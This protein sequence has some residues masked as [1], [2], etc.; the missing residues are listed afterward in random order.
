MKNGEPVG[1]TWSFPTIKL[2]GT[3]SNDLRVFPS[4][5]KP[6]HQEIW[7]FSELQ[8]MV[9]IGGTDILI[10][11]YG[12]RHSDEFSLYPRVRTVEHADLKPSIPPFS[13]VNLQDSHGGFPKSWGY[14]IN[15]HLYPLVMTNIAMEVMA[16]RNRWF[17]Q[18]EASIYFW[19]SPWL[20]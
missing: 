7:T 16:H 4:H 9:K 5:V 2:V 15:H 18:L 3:F 13:E 1:A 10:Y 19:D 20:C 8:M 6:V 17:S 14:P 12:H 11:L